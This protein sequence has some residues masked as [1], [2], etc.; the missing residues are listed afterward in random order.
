MNVRSY[1]W[2]K[3]IS[4]PVNK[5]I[6]LL[7]NSFSSQIS[8]ACHRPIWLWRSLRLNIESIFYDFLIVFFRL[9]KTNFLLIQNKPLATTTFFSLFFEIL[10]GFEQLKKIFIK[11][12]KQI[13][14]IQ[15]SK[16]VITR[17]ADEMPTTTTMIFGLIILV[18]CSILLRSSQPHSA[19]PGPPGFSID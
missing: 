17:L 7:I 9:N 2:K 4:Y 5:S 12:P 8:W 15:I 6:F 13:F 1:F 16:F 3:C 18:Y 19:P 11:Q 14:N 10:F